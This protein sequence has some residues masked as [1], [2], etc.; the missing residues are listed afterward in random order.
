M[1][2]YPLARISDHGHF[3]EF[4]YSTKP[5]TT[6]GAVLHYFSCINISREFW[7]D[8]RKCVELFRDL[9][10]LPDDRRFGIYHDPKK[11]SASADYL[12]DRGGVVYELCPPGVTTWHA[13]RSMFRGRTRCNDFMAGIELIAA[14]QIDPVH[15]GYTDPQYWS[16]AMLLRWIM[17]EHG[18]DA[19]QITGHDTV[20]GNWNDTHQDDKGRIKTDPGTYAK[21]EPW[22]DWKKLNRYMN[23]G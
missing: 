12:V 14:P 11:I 17:L 6:E 5:R 15:F 3:P 19:D 7:D 1:N 22:F 18:F 21:P 23:G 16:T 10:C 20:R 13:G 8:P 9:N 4:C 2:R